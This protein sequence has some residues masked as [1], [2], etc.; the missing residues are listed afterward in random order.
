MSVVSIICTVKK[1]LKVAAADEVPFVH[2]DGARRAGASARPQPWE[3]R[4]ALA[5]SHASDCRWS[6]RVARPP[7][8]PVP[9]A[10]MHDRGR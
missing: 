8:S 6:R 5:D 10:C 4:P 1:F 2:G 7:T 9:V 3:A